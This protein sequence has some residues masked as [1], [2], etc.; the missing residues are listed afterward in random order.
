[1]VDEAAQL[2]RY[3]MHP[4]GGCTGALA[5]AEAELGPQ[6]TRLAAIKLLSWMSYRA[7]A[8]SRPMIKASPLRLDESGQWARD[9]AAFVDRFGIM[10][11]LLEIQDDTVELR[12]SHPASDTDAVLDAI[13]AGYRP[14]L[15]R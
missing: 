3:V 10:R 6:R 7:R 14:R 8:R 12:P 1:M 5:E 9:V 15:M 11:S 2:V 13:D 4:G